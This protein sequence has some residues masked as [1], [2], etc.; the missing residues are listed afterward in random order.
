MTKATASDG[1]LQE[2]TKCR[3]TTPNGTIRLKVLPEITDSKG[4]N[5]QNEPVI[6]RT[7]PV[8]NYSYSEPRTIQSEL[9]FIVTKCED[10]YDNLKYLRL[11]ESLV[12]PGPA[13]GGAPYTPPP[14]CK[15]ICGKLLGDQGVC[16][17]LKNYSTRFQSDVAWDA[18]TYLPYKLTVSCSWEVV[19]ACGDLP[20]NNHIRAITQDWICPTTA[21]DG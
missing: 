4:A 1:S 14:V 7:A 2:L 6:G 11:L 15:F 3:I 20:T 5:Y 12:Y 16:V 13:T 21:N 10:I 18:A 9:T 8:T 17:I 19:Y